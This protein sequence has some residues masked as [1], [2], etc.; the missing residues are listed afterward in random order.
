MPRWQYNLY[1]GKEV[2]TEKAW[3]NRREKVSGAGFEPGHRSLRRSTLYD[4]N[5]LAHYSTDRWG[6]GGK[7]IK[8][9]NGIV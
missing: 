6:F 3:F 1:V 4:E 8:N 2:C 5:A 7:I 9:R